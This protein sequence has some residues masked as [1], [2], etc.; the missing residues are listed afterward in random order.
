MS[1]SKLTSSWSTNT[2]EIFTTHFPPEWIEELYQ[3]YRSYIQKHPP[4]NIKF[5][6]SPGEYYFQTSGNSSCSL[7]KYTTGYFKGLLYPP[8]I[9]ALEYIIV[10]LNTFQNLKV[11]DNGCGVGM[12]SVFLQKLGIECYNQDSLQQVGNVPVFDQHIKEFMTIHPVTSDVPD[13]AQV[14]ISMGM[15]CDNP[16]YLNL[17]DVKYF[18]IDSVWRD[19]GVARDLKNKFHLSEDDELDPGGLI[20]VYRN[21]MEDV[22]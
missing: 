14:I 16:E 1:N 5:F 11:I 8:N 9:S 15:W 19:K 22:F 7:L 20:G 13:D 2:L 17:S 21:P 12:L 3:L 4:K 18:I 10:N 6:E